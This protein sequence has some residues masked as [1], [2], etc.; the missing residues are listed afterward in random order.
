MYVRNSW[1]VVAS[2]K[3]VTDAPLAR[4]ILNESL[5][6]FRGENGKIGV[7]ENR[8]PHRHVPLS[9]GKVRGNVLQCGYHGL[10]V[11]AGGKCV[12]VPSQNFTPPNAD[13]KSYPAEERHGWIWIWAGDP[14]MAEP[15]RIPDFHQ[16][17]GAGFASVGDLIHVSAGY[18]LIVDNLLDLSHVGYVHTS[19]IGAAGMG[20]K[21]RLKSETTERGVRIARVVPDATPPPTYIKQGFPENERMDRFQII[22][23]IAPCFVLIHAG[24]GIAGTGILEGGTDTKYKFWIINAVTPETETTSH[25]FW[26]VA[27]QFSIDDPEIGN[28]LYAETA[29]AFGEDQVVIEAQQ[30]ALNEREDTW[31]VALRQ[32]AGSIQ[33]RRFR[34][35]MLAEEAAAVT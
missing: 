19:T 13:I 11:D 21:G 33:A 31:S 35:R 29:R 30:L 1:Y 34:D 10:M 25:Y 8:C 6:V 27:R 32:D 12:G 3:E 15:A 2:S 23:F 17:D 4:R 5:V 22:D 16:L 24:G 26:S 18:H 20:E 14:Q 28:I 7:L 9:L